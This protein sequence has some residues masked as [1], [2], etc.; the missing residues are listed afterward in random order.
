[1]RAAARGAA[2]LLLVGFASVADAETS[3]GPRVIETKPL[4]LIGDGAATSAP[5]RRDA[6]TIATPPLRLVGD[7]AKPPRREA[8]PSMPITIETRPLKLIGAKP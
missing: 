8:A 5:P 2:V 1:M 4:K 7:G 6:I 3:G